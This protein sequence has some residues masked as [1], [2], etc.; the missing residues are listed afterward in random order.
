VCRKTVDDGRQ[1]W[2]A[3]TGKD[4]KNG[5]PIEIRIASFVLKGTPYHMLELTLD[6]I[7]VYIYYKPLSIYNGKIVVDNNSA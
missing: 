4:Y 3:R 5:F 1:A 7:K 2:S 6:Q